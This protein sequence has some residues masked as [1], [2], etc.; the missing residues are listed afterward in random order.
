[1]FRAIQLLFLPLGLLVQFAG[2]A[3]KPFGLF[4][5]AAFG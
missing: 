4:R 5:P 3:Q 2:F 1:M